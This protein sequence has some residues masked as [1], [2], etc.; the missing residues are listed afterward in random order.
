MFEECDDL[1]DNI[2]VLLENVIM[3]ICLRCVMVGDLFET[4][5]D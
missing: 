1:L 2:E 5:A 3:M 4:R